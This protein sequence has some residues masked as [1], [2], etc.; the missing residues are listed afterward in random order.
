MRLQWADMYCSPQNVT[1]SGDNDQII[2]LKEML[3]AG[4]VFN[5]KLFFN[6]AYYSPHMQAI[7]DE[8]HMNIEG[9]ESG[10]R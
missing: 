7:A 8:Y 3:D 1:I 6:V 2:V 9:I 5:R 10:P 4:S